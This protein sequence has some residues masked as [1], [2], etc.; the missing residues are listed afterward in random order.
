MQG[1]IAFS[2]I[3]LRL[4]SMIGLVMTEVSLLFGLLVLINRLFRKLTILGY[5]VAPMPARLPS[6]FLERSLPV[7]CSFASASLANT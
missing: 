4:A 5:W 7:S 1:L 6:Y 2:S 3:P